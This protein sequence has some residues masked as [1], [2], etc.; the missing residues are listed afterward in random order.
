MPQRDTPPHK[1]DPATL[2]ALYPTPKTYDE[3]RAELAA[4]QARRKAARPKYVPLKVAL[5]TTGAA[6]A[7]TAF[8]SAFPGMIQEGS[9]NAISSTFLLG[10]VLMG[11]VWWVYRQASGWYDEYGLSGLVFFF[12][13]LAIALVCMG[14]MQLGRAFWP[15]WLWGITAGAHLLLVYLTVHFTLAKAE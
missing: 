3:H 9:I 4:R 14:L 13:Y 5:L 7:W 12:S 6:L 10:L 11:A 2:G 15:Q 8:L 1:I